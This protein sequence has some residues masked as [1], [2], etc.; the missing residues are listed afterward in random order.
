MSFALDAWTS[1]N[2]YGF[3]AITVHWITKNWKLCDSLLDFIKLSGPHSGENICNAFVKSC[4]D[5]GILEKVNFSIFYL[6]FENTC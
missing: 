4:D 1:I 5:F 3:L 6:N 2:G